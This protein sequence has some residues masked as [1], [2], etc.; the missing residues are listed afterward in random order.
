[1]PNSDFV[2]LFVDYTKEFES[3][4]S[5]WTWAAYAGIA[6]TLRS[7]CH[8]KW[9]SSNLYPNIY[10][11]LLADSA[12]YRKDAGPDLISDLLKESSH[13][14]V[15]KGRSSWQGIVDELSQDI[16]NKKSGVPLR[17][18]SGIIIATEF[19]AS[20]VEDN[21]LIQM[22][23]E[24][25]SFESEYEYTLRGGKVKIKDRCLTLLGGSNETLLRDLFNAKATYG[26]LL[27]RTCLIKPDKRR[28][29]NALVD[30]NTSLDPTKKK[31]L[32]DF[33]NRIKTL[34]GEFVLSHDAKV[35]YRDWYHKLYESYDK[36]DDK[37]GFVQGIHTLIIKLSMIIAASYE[38]LIIDETMIN[39]AIKEVI[40]LKENYTNYTM[41]AGKHPQANMGALIISSLWQESLTNGSHGIKRRDILL[42]YWNEISSEELDK[43][44]I[45][46]EAAGLINMIPRGNEPNYILT[47]NAKDI[48]LKDMQTK[49]KGTN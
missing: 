35:A 28:P 45:T 8:I 15:I 47:Q 37:T 32:L 41:G 26:G 46:L 10:V 9:G 49:S 13:T 43:L 31:S 38:V 33:L 14:K 5:F 22:M 1:M 29:P 34:K 12:A 40:N 44:I 39:R 25:Y 36:F 48:F 23:T 6:A 2:T 17:G 27:R 7:N 11:L 24:A 3:P 42:K 4:T 20:F 18:G 30:G 16:P 19:T 21:H